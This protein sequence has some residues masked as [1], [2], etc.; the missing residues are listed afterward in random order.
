MP[1]QARDTAGTEKWLRP[2]EVA[3]MLRVSTSSVSRWAAG[4]LIPSIRTPGG[5]RRYRESDVRAILNGAI[6]GRS[7]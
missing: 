3:E 5:H 4:G 6:R 1:S 7:S 2:A